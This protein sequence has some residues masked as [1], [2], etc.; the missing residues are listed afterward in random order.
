MPARLKGVVKDLGGKEYDGLI[1][2]DKDEK[3][4]L[5][6]LEGNYK[7]SKYII[8]FREIKTIIPKNESYSYVIL[9]SDKKLL[10]GDLQDV[11]SK[12]EGVVVIQK[13]NT[14]PIHLDWED[15]DEIHFH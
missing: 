15:V 11:S 13:D 12:N 7:S 1:I 4:D 6:Q 3:W 2:F 10:L 9:R 14:E 8:P 5:E